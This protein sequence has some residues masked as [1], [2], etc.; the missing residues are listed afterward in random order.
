[1]WTQIVFYRTRTPP[2]SPFNCLPLF[3]TPHPDASLFS[4]FF[5]YPPLTCP[6]KILQQ[7]EG[8]RRRCVYSPS[9]QPV[10]LFCLSCVV[11]LRRDYL[12]HN[13]K[14][15]KKKTERRE[16][17]DLDSSTETGV[18]SRRVSILLAVTIVRLHEGKVE[19]KLSA[20]HMAASTHSSREVVTRRSA[21]SKE[22]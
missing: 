19:Q 11:V 22:C 16:L 5:F 17:S 7:A 6:V 14:P 3:P 18:Q 12:E 8:G 10:P 9:A 13:R 15:A 20:L 1:M 2:P 21:R 4:R